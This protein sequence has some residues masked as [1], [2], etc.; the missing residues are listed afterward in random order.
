[1]SAKI[2]NAGNDIGNRR[3]KKADFKERKSL[4]ATRISEAKKRREG[5]TKN[6]V[7]CTVF[8]AERQGVFRER[9]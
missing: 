5:P 4:H 6:H 8:R 9:V 1:L 3:A 2:S 7:H